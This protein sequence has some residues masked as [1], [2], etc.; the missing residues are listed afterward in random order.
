MRKGILFILLLGLTVQVT[1]LDFQIADSCSDPYNV[2]LFSISNGTNGHVAEPDFYETNV[3]ADDVGET[4]IAQDCNSITNPVL[5]F[6]ETDNGTSHLA[7]EGD[8]FTYALCSERLATSVWK[9]CPGNTVP[10]VSIYGPVEDH[11]ATPGHY[12]W[13][14]CGGVFE[15]ATLAYEFTISGNKDFLLNGDPEDSSIETTS[16]LPGYAAVQNDT[17]VSGIVGNDKQPQTTGIN[18]NSGRAELNHTLIGNTNNQW[19]IPLTTGD[20]FD[21]EGRLDRI[22]DNTFL[23]YFNPNFAFTLAEEAQIKVSLMLDSIDIVNDVRL[24]PGF[25]RVIIENMGTNA[26]GVPEVEVNATTP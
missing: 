19:F 24:G 5:S 13:Q 26:D 17:I 15:N 6:Y 18:N 10:I 12:T 14:I 3:C 20:Y 21:I 23:N 9:E 22:Q 11:V 7:S 16:D 2:K 8:H 1:A 4:R 25:H